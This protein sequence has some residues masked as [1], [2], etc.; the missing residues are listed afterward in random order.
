MHLHEKVEGNALAPEEIRIHAGGTN[1]ANQFG[2]CG[3]VVAHR[4]RTGCLISIIDSSREP[5]LHNPAVQLM[6]GRRGR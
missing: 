2:D 5:E 3:G 4:R 1:Q 6:R